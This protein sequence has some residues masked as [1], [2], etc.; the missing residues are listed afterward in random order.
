MTQLKQPTVGDVVVHRTGMIRHVVTATGLACVARELED[1]QRWTSFYHPEELEVVEPADSDSY[2]RRVSMEAAPPRFGVREDIADLAKDDPEHHLRKMAN[3]ASAALRALGWDVLSPHGKEIGWR[4]VP[5]G[6]SQ[7]AAHGPEESVDV[8]LPRHCHGDRAHHET[9]PGDPV[10]GRAAEILLDGHPYTV[11]NQSNRPTIGLRDAV[12]G[13]IERL[14]ID[15]AVGR[16]SCAGYAVIAPDD[17]TLER[18]RELAQRFSEIREEAD[19]DGTPV[20]IGHAL[21]IAVWS[22]GHCVELAESGSLPAHFAHGMR[23]AIDQTLC[24]ACDH[25]PATAGA[26][27]G[28]G[29]LPRG[30]DD[31]CDEW[32]RTEDRLAAKGWR[33]DRQGG[34]SDQPPA[35]L[36]VEQHIAALEAGGYTVAPKKTSGLRHRAACF[37]DCRYLISCDDGPW[38][39]QHGYQVHVSPDE[40]NDACLGMEPESDYP[41]LPAGLEDAAL[42]EQLD[43]LRSNGLPT[44]K[45]SGKK[46]KTAMV[47]K[48]LRLGYYTPDTV[49]QLTGE[50]QWPPGPAKCPECGSGEPEDCECPLP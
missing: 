45:G 31:S 26:H 1:G 47:V 9:P 33:A 10:N 16:L 32:V 15:E 27:C 25:W 41:A 2:P 18:M 30:C 50:L 6:A 23:E 24:L 14:S 17:D 7:I 22:L 34:V 37:H 44:G 5:P 28:A 20:P 43:W 42:S 3:G 4:I 49:E 11:A 35:P 40:V 38:R 21:D 36:T 48:L 13:M 19:G 39:C 29:R 46:A 8:P 12:D